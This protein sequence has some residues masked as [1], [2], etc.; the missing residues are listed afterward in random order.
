MANILVWGKT[1]D[2]ISGEIPAGIT[3]AEAA[4]LAAVQAVVEGKGSTLVLADPVRLEAEKAALEAWI[5]AGGHRRALLVA[6]ADAEAA[7]DL[8]R[9][10]PFLDDVLIK[11]LSAARLRLRLDRALDTINSRRVIEQLDDA[12]VRKSQEL[13]ELNSIGV[14]L[15]AQRDIDKLLELILLKCREITAADAGSLYLVERGKDVDKSADDL[16][17]FKLPQNDSVT[18]GAFEEFTMPLSE[19]SIAGYAALS[20]DIVNVADAYQLPA[21]SPFKV[22]R[23]FDEKSGYRSKSMLVVPMRDH[24][25]TVI[26][27]IQLINKK[28][29][30]RIVLQPVQLVEETVIPFTSVDEELVTSLASQAAVAFENAR[31]IQDIKDLFESFVTASVTAVESRDPTTSGHSRRVATLT[32]GIGEKLDSL[33][34]EPF[35]QLRF[36]RD[37][38]QEIK[39]AS[40][41]HDFGKVGVRE[42]VLIKGKKLYVGEMLLIKQRF[43]YIKR[44]LEAEH[45]RAKLEQLQSGLTAPDLLA[46]MDRAYDAQREEIDALL[47]TIMQANEPTILEEESFRALMDLTSRSFADADGG[48]QPFLTPNEVSALSIRKGSLSEK[49]RREIESHVTHT[50]LFLSQIPWTGEFRRVPEIAYA[51]H[52]KMDGTGYPRRLKAAEIPIQSRMMAISD[53][54]D[55]LVAWDRPYKKAVPVEKALNILRDESGMGKLDRQIL[56]V[57]IDAKIYEKTLPRAGAEAAEI[58]R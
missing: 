6:A 23:L 41:L 26:G 35:R 16:L 13:H 31:L 56:E 2:L 3:T 33:E 30:F 58:A 55:A 57:F 50:F 34:S 53:I 5:R 38:L 15:S 48:R 4:T 1:R 19:A 22:S 52:E 27:V 43:E 12:L 8:I 46:E 49:E 29:D 17:R 20:G 28:R 24:Q 36:T 14:A 45:Y 51:H 10:F 42:K 40:L 9:R 7:D 32:V 25:N 18:V 44:T 11:P 21:G 37:Q 39:Y 54:F 47:R